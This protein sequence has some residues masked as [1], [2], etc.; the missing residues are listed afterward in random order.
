MED[1]TINTGGEDSKEVKGQLLTLK[2]LFFGILF[3]MVLFLGVVFLLRAKGGSLEA[4]MRIIRIMTVISMIVTAVGV[5]VSV[6]VRMNVER[7]MGRADSFPKALGKYLCTMV[8]TLAVCE[9]GAM[10]CVVTIMLG[11]RET[12]LLTMFCVAM[13]A[14]WL[15]FPGKGRLADAYE[16]GRRH[17]EEK[18]RLGETGN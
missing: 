15:H 5:F 16:M 13:I 14:M 10:I 7:I 3:G 18:Q 12:I 11:G 1:M 8:L 6:V 4:D 17:Y 9:A 2:I